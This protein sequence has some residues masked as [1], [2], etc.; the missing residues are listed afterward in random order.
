MDLRQELVVDGGLIKNDV[1]DFQGVRLLNNEGT[2]TSYGSDGYSISNN[3]TMRADTISA[4][5]TGSNGP[6]GTIITHDDPD[7]KD[8]SGPKGV[9]GPTGIQYYTSGM[10]LSSDGR[11]I[12]TNG[13]TIGVTG[14]RGCVGTIPSNLSNTF[15]L[16]G[17]GGDS[18]KGG[19]HDF[20]GDR[21][22]FN[23]FYGNN[24]T[25]SGIVLNCEPPKPKFV[26]LKSTLS[27]KAILRYMDMGKIVIEPFVEKQLNTS[28]YDVTLGEYFYREQTSDLTIY[29]IYSEEHV[30]KV[31]GIYETAK[32]YKFYQE[33]Q[34][35]VLE[36]ISDE[37]LII[38]IKP[39][40]TI[41]AHTNEYIGGV[42][43][44]T[45]M[46]KSRSSLGRNFIEVCKCAG[47][48]DVGYYNR[49]TMEITNNSNLYTIPLVVGRRIAQIVFFDTEGIVEKSYNESGKYQT[50]SSLTE[51]K[52]LGS[53]KVCFLKCITI[54]KLI[55][56]FYK[57]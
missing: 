5:I 15:M 52:N 51:L 44:V 35:I 36:N 53:Q 39:Q 4:G 16:S 18:R 10:V 20:I 38:F 29:N 40:E 41:L 57:R 12:S 19:I 14:P 21:Y 34:N 42:D 9:P 56:L 45:T 26:S 22:V 23:S 11:S 37:E 8:I 32:S 46:M 43:T 28:S 30:G 25:A 17:S 6:Y 7:I 49:W 33:T 48:G 50:S 3:G 2:I 54:M 27:D 13:D 1:I 24:N 31:W 47:W 55:H